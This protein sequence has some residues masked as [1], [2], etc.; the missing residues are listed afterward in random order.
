MRTIILSPAQVERLVDEEALVCAGC[1]EHVCGEL[2][3]ADPA[4]GAEFSHRDGSTLCA[5][6]RGRACGPIEATQ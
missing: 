3:A 2:P 5:D 4:V 6:K 1:H